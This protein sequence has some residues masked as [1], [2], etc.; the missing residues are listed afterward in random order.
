MTTHSQPWMSPVQKFFASLA[1]VA[2]L[3]IVVACGGGNRQQPVPS[4][5]ESYPRS[6]ALDRIIETHVE[7]GTDTRYE[8]TLLT[9][10]FL[11]GDPRVARFMSLTPAGKC[12]RYQYVHSAEWSGPPQPSQ[13]TAEQLATVLR[14][15]SELPPSGKPSLENMLIV[16][17][18]KDG[19]WETR[20]YDRTQRPPALST[21]F[22]TTNSP[23][24]P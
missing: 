6:E 18:K 19:V 10:W 14:S 24:I 23:I 20:L 2:G 8:R 9:T 5:F 11:D 3:A 15:I 4:L 7:A 12:A 16:S 21:I 22:E 13:L 1:V 17:F